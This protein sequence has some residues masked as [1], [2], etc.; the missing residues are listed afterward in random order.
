MGCLLFAWWYGNSPYECEFEDPKASIAN[1]FTL[2]QCYGERVVACSHLR[3][4]TSPSRHPT[5][6]FDK[7]VLDGL[8]SS[9]I[10]DE[11]VSLVLVQDISK[12]PFLKD[13]KLHVVSYI[14]R[15]KANEGIV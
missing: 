9:D 11:L 4:L 13:F 6:T 5:C 3:V 12:R 8:S 7:P 1:D 14:D 2:Q 10:V 15:L